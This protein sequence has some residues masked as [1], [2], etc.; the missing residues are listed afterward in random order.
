MRTAQK[1]SRQRANIE[2]L[3]PRVS[4]RSF[5]SRALQGSARSV[6]LVAGSAASLPPRRCTARTDTE[7]AAALT[8]KHPRAPCTLQFVESLG[9]LSLLRM[10]YFVVRSTRGC[11]A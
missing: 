4:F 1:G 7:R 11:R 3:L 10:L 9:K 6:G 8:G 5:S 2:R